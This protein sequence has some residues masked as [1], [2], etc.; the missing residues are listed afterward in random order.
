[1]ATQAGDGAA[2]NLTRGF[3]NQSEFPGFVRG[4][5]QL[6]QIWTLLPPYLGVSP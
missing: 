1:M 4:Y 5:L 2:L 3:Q 6:G